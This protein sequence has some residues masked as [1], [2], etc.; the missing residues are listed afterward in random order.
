[1]AA[2][3]YYICPICDGKALYDA[4]E[5]GVGQADVEVLHRECLAKDRAERERALRE[6]IDGE[7][8]EFAKEA[9][10]TDDPAAIL[11]IIAAAVIVS[12]KR[13]GSFDELAD[14]LDELLDD[15]G[16]AVPNA[17]A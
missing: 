8:R 17:E 3:D 16:K 12:G 5:Y 4:D 10:R 7:I 14:E 11:G 15:E 2:S 13:A 9:A 1:M 6:Q